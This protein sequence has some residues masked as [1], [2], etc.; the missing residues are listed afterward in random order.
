MVAFVVSHVLSFVSILQYP[1][2]DHSFSLITRFPTLRHK[3]QTS[4]HPF[5]GPHNVIPTQHNTISQDVVRKTDGL[6]ARQHRH[7]NTN[8]DRS[9]LYSQGWWDTGKG[10][11]LELGVPARPSR[12]AL[13][14]GRKHLSARNITQ[15]RGR[16]VE[17]F[18]ITFSPVLQ[19]PASACFGPNLAGSQWRVH[20]KNR[21]EQDKDKT[22]N[23]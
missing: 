9:C 13:E 1:Q 3:M 15:H 18:W 4:Q 6:V 14:G 22:A 2:W 11:L 5:Q 8:I 19:S 23:R 17:I 21:A 10:M 12:P 7:Q 20:L 16:M